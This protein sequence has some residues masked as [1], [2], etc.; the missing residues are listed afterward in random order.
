MKSVN[1]PVC[2]FVVSLLTCH[3]TTNTCVKNVKSLVPS[4]LTL[5]KPLW[6]TLFH[7][8][9]ILHFIR[10]RFNFARAHNFREVIA[11]GFD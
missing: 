2:F 9:T 7:N 3:P 6:S 8:K 4:I 5:T 1:L 11:F 10:Q